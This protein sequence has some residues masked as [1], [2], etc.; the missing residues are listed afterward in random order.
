MSKRTISA[1]LRNIDGLIFTID[2]EDIISEGE[3]YYDQIHDTTFTIQKGEQ[4]AYADKDPGWAE[5]P[6]CLLFQ[7]IAH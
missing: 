1:A 6:M 3:T 4:I 7:K 5:A 2:T